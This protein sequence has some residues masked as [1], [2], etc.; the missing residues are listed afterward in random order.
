LVDVPNLNDEVTD[1]VMPSNITI[2]NGVVKPF[3]GSSYICYRGALTSGNWTHI[4]ENGDPDENTSYPFIGHTNIRDNAT[5]DLLFGVPDKVFYT[6]TS[7]PNNNLY[8]YHEQSITRI[9]NKFGKQIECQ[10]WLLP[11]DVNRLNLRT[12]KLIDGVKFYI[13]KIS[14]YDAQQ[15]VNT[16][17]ELIKI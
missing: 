12:I 17:V 7:Y 10:M 8:S 16:T 1:L 2:D 5:F 3:K 15:N 14:E 4:D 6:V 9:V 13:Q 11:L